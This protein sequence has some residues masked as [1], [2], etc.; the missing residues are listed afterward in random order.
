MTTRNTTWSRIV[1]LSRLQS[2]GIAYHRGLC[3]N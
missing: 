2:L 1:K 3:A